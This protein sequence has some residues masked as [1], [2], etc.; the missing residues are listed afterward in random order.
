MNYAMVPYHYQFQEEWD[1]ATQRKKFY[2]DNFFHGRSRNPGSTGCG[3]W[4]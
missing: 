3:L 2:M 1:N 4:S